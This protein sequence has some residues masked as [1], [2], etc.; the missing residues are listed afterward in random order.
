M[1][2]LFYQYL[3]PLS[4]LL[5]SFL[6]SGSVSKQ[7]EISKPRI[8]VT[9]D[10]EID[11]KTSFM[12]FLLYSNEFD[13]EGLIYGN[14]MWQKHGHG[15]VWMQEMIDEYGKI[16]PNLLKHLPGY[17]TV[18]ELKKIIYAGN[19]EEK[20]L[21]YSGPLETEGAKHIINILL[22]GNPEPVWVQ[23]WGG[24]NTIAQAL[25]VLRRDYSEKEINGA[26]EKLW[27]F[28]IADQDKTSDWIRENFPKVKYIRS[29]QFVALNYQ[30]EG[31]PYSNHYI[32]DNE[33]TTKNVKENHGNYGKLYAQKYFSEG[34]S[35]A[36]FHLINNGLRRTKIQHTEVGEAGSKQKTGITISMQPTTGIG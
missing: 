29:H 14:S 23:A 6:C 3:F 24:T 12:R 2:K 7:K 9:T 21:D 1:K 19:M 28:A 22:D 32:F 35:P 11:D 26:L 18:N 30:H 10:G 17:P 27:I 34:D 8:I 33:W 5:N 31:H 16:R 25:S 20:Y 15:V 36:F 13:I 4:I